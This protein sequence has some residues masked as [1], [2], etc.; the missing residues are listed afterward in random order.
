MH[1]SGAWRDR[2]AH[3]SVRDSDV[4]LAACAQALGAIGFTGPTV[5]E[6][7]DGVDPQD[8]LAAD[9]ALFTA[10]GWET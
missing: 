3:A 7:V 1:V 5:Y 4:D 8:R 2:W 6:L 9:L 10:G